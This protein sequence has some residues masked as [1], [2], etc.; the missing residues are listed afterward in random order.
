MMTRLELS[1][2][3]RYMRSRR[4]SR[5]LSLISTIAILG[6]TVA[7]SAL[8]VI[9]G[10]MDGL[11]TDLREKILIGSPDIRVMTYGEDLVMSDWKS[12]LAKVLRQ[13]GVVAA[14]PFVHTQA[15]INAGHHKYLEAVFVEGLPPDGPG[16]PQ[17][18]TIRERAT[19]GNFRFETLDGQH[20]GAVL[21]SKLADK[22]N[23]TPGIDSITL[24]SIDQ[25]HLD[26][27]TGFPKATTL[28][29][30]VTGIFDTGMYE[31][32][33]SYV[34]VS[35]ETAQQL[36]QLGGAV[37]GIEVKTPTR[38][39]APEIGQR[40]TDSLGAVRVLD[41]HQQNNQL[42]SALK[43]EKLGMSV[44]LLL[45]VLV[46]AFNIIST[47]VMVVTD[48]TREIGILRAM[49]MPARS[50]RRLFFAQGL[51]IGGVG[52]GAGLLLG[53]VA[54][55]VIGRNKLIALDPTIYFIDHLPV[56]T[57]PLD[58]TLIV[59]ASLAVAALATVYPALQAARLYPVEA[60]RHE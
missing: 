55:T 56:A 35:L 52:T 5:L 58:V 57:Q 46:A 39:D 25:K 26:S 11:Q 13:K 9:I 41:W 10:V 48:K 37:T 60:I 51:V 8:I 12:M 1:I 4:G 16:V 18:T 30:E 17:V 53:L 34:I 2:A 59:V 23:V 24:L 15:L 31:Y 22:L 49:G 40:L 14:G 21:G 50:I 47:L 3:W 6:V 45:I 33:N 54:A 44:I 19:A 29:L 36:A 28:R 38:W 27:V 43:L 20:H 32:D 7:V 42:F